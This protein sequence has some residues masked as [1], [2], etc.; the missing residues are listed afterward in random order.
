MYYRAQ[1]IG[2]VVMLL[3][4]LVVLSGCS[5]KPK[6]TIVGTWQDNNEAILTFTT[7]FCEECRTHGDNW[8]YIRDESGEPVGAYQFLDDDTV[9]LRG[10]G[11]NM[12]VDVEVDGER[13]FFSLWN[14]VPQL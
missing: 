9:A 12:V 7:E 2:S 3:L 1:T 13:L 5:Q 4:S 6:D 11:L 10:W 14:R 8:F